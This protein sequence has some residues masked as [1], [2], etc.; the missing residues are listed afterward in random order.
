M[1]SQDDLNH[2]Y[3]YVSSDKPRLFL[4]LGSIKV[5]VSQEAWNFFCRQTV[6]LKDFKQGELDIKKAALLEILLVKG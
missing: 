3:R 1:R 2:S 6:S 4:T 5:R